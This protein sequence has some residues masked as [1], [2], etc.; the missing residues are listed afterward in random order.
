MS[1]AGIVFGAGLAVSPL[2]LSLTM[3]P[4]SWLRSAV[5]VA[6]LACFTVAA[7]QAGAPPFL[8]AAL[9]LSALGDFALSRDGRAAFLFGLSA[10]GLAHLC[11][12]ILFHGLGSQGAIEAFSV[13]PILAAIVVVAAL[14][15]EIWLA[16]FT[17]AM[18]WPVR[19]YVA[20]IAYMALTALAL[21]VGFGLVIFGAL[22]FI[23]SDAILSVS[24]FRFKP[25][26][27][28]QRGAAWSLWVLYIAAVALITWGTGAI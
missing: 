1:I 9:F 11:F 23:A 13:R 7:W 26:G 15:S 25:D 4:V 27:S 2:Y 18:R 5:K 3:K 12:A 19:G 24:L 28:R 6:P 22:L 21:S 20:L 16:P 17:G 14:S 8:V 10:F